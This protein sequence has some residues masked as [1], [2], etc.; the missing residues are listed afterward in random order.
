M[1]PMILSILMMSLATGTIITMTSYHWLLAW[2]GLE[3]NTLSILPIIST[4]HTPRSTE[5]AT[6]YF[7]VQAAASAMILFSSTANAWQTGSWDI[8][9]L[10]TTPS[11][12]TLTFALAMK[13]GLAP[14]HFW[15]PEVLQGTTLASALIITTWQKLA[16]MALIFLTINNLSTTILITLGMTSAI[17]GGWGGL[18]Q[19]QTRKVMAFSSIAHLGWMTAISPIMMNIM[20]FNLMVYLM[21][22]TAL[23]YTLILSNTKTLQDTTMTWT[24]SPMMTTMMMIL[25]LSLGGLPPLTGFTPKWLILEGLITQ[26]LIFPATILVVASLLSLFFYLRLAYTTALTLSPNTLQTKLKWRFKPTLPSSP[27]ATLF[28]LSAFLLPMTPIALL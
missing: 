16:P 6:K 23:F 28:T 25:I 22:T 11:C 9:N 12:T 18:N 10:T 21:M 20:I 26:N 13:L 5:A 7:L 4:S 24:V 19:T 3:I 2:V 27:L 1:S 15:L 17:A 8:T 14:V